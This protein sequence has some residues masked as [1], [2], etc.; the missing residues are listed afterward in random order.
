MELGIDVSE[1]CVEDDKDVLRGQRQP[2][3][4]KF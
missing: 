3:G 2:V 4:V 1:A